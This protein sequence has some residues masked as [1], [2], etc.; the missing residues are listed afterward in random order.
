VGPDGTGTIHDV[1]VAGITG[2]VVQAGPCDHGSDWVSSR[3][4][5]GYA[6]PF[7]RYD[8]PTPFVRLDAEF[9][10]RNPY[11]ELGAQICDFAADAFA[12]K[13]PGVIVKKAPVR[14]YDDD[15]VADDVD[16]D[17]SNPAVK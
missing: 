11:R 10:M 8:S 3:G 12:G 7:T 2:V 9:P 6:I 13:V 14:D 15:G 5:H 4:T 1:P 16:A 17:P